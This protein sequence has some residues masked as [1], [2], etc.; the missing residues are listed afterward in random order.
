[1]LHTVF[2]HD[3]VAAWKTKADTVDI[4]EKVYLMYHCLKSNMV[5]LFIITNRFTHIYI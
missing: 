2:V 3:G 1:M 5:Q 4:E